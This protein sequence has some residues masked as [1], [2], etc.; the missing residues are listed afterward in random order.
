MLSEKEKLTQIIDLGIEIAQYKD[1]DLVL[2]R[3]LTLARKF[4]NAEA[5]SVYIKEGDNLRFSN[6]QNEVLSGQ[7]PPG[8]KL[9]YSSFLVPV[10]CKSIAGHVASTGEMLNIADV[11]ELPASTS[12]SFDKGYDELSNYRTRSMLTFPLKTGH[13]GVIGVLQLINARDREGNTVPFSKEDEPFVMHFAGNAA[14]AIERAQM[15]RAIIM[16]VIKMAELRDPKETGAHVNR[17]A[18]YAVEIYE[19]WASRRGMPADEIERDRDILR[20]GSMLHDV[21]KVA[22]SDS[23]LKKPA[24]L[25]Q[26]E[27][28]IMKQ[29][30]VLGARLFADKYSEFDEAAAVIALNHHERW[31]GNGYPGH[32]EVASGKPLPGYEDDNG[33]ARGKKGL[34]IPAFGRVVAIADVYDAL[35]S[36]RSYKEAWDESKVLDNLRRE[37]GRQFDPEMV[38]AFFSCVDVIR[39]IAKRYPD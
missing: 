32:V 8:K 37:A 31:D 21:G 39:N 23:I 18:A 28:E 4:V 10:N 17:V 5:G 20:M 3:I 24:R 2:E 15:T 19:E 27:F 34:E 6:S 7:L 30:T 26:A 11:Y 38:E 35:S 22:V 14:V 25:D 9:V 29:H 12:Y 33:K 16:R 36:K 1:I 13:G